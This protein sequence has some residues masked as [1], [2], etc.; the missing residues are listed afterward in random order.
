MIGLFGVSLT[1]S[2]CSNFNQASTGTEL[3]TDE[4]NRGISNANGNGVKSAGEA[5]GNATVATLAGH[6][7][8]LSGNTNTGNAGNAAVAAGGAIG[9]GGATAKGAIGTAVGATILNSK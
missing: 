4:I 8:R 1:L 9:T 3:K 2:S 5:A 6:N 7:A